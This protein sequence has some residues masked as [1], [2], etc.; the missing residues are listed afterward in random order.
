MIPREDASGFP[1]DNMT[2]LG[3]MLLGIRR[4]RGKV[5]LVL[6]KSDIAEAY[7]LLP[8]HPYW[9]I[10]QINTINGQRMVDRN[11]CF[12]G[13]GSGGIFISFDSLVTWIAKEI[14]EI[15]Y[16][17]AYSDDSFG[18]DEE[19]NSTW[20]D[21]YSRSMPERQVRLLSLWDELGI[22]HEEQKQVSG[23]RLDIIGIT[24]DP[25]MG[26]VFGLGP[27]GPPF[28]ISRPTQ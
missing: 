25:M 6:F 20:Y 8:V 17:G 11:N 2:H 23:A 21:K 7:R 22:P 19:G 13:R 14:K 1:L 24:V 26:V 3:E 9:Q 5:P 18:V 12:G 28:S 16:L 10:K 4:T 15:P 27:E